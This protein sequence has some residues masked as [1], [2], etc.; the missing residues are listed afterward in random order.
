MSSEIGSSAAS[1]RGRAACRGRLHLGTR[2]RGERPVTGDA[3]RVGR[4]R[5][6]VHGRRGRGRA[7]L[8]AGRLPMGRDARSGGHDG[9]RPVLARLRR[10]RMAR[11][12]RRQLLRPGRVRPVATGGWAAAERAVPQRRGRVRRRQ[13]G[14]RG[15]P[16]TSAAAGASPPTSIWMVTRTCTSRRATVGAL[17]WNEGD[18]TFTEGAEEAG[19]QAFGWYAGAAV[20]DVD[21]NGW[22]DLFLAGYANVNAPIEGATQGFPNTNLGVRDLLYLNEGEE[23]DGRVRVPRGRHGGRARGRRVR[24]RARRGVLRPG[25]RRR[26]RPLPG[27][28]HEA[29]P[30]VRQRPVAG[31]GRGGSRRGSGSASRSSPREPAWPTRTPGW[32]SREADYDGDGLPD[33]FVTNARGQVHAR[34]PRAALGSGE[35]LVRGRAGRSRTGPGRRDR[36]GGLVRRSGPGHRSRSVRGQRGRAR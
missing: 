21:G 35:P 6:A 23:D 3:G 34:V 13:F 26:S 19:V 25:P 33:L 8:P 18:G 20:G 4:V 27:Q 2:R 36:L 17:L 10:G 31:R 15:R 32:G 14:I 22:P 5:S 12:V 30:P 11:P 16:R 9:W 1:R 7:R 24:V 28:R 29:Q